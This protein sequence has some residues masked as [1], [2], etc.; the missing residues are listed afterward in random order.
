MALV[1]LVATESSATFRAVRGNYTKRLAWLRER[2][3]ADED[4]V[5]GLSVHQA[6]GRE[7]DTVGLALKPSHIEHLHGGL[8]YTESTHRELYVACT[9]ARVRTI[10]V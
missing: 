4:L 3:E 6:K 10:A 1:N 2:L 8:S 7:W 9:R 5:L